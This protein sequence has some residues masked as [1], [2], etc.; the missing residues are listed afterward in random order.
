MSEEKLGYGV[1]DATVRLLRGCLKDIE[2]KKMG[3]KKQID[4]ARSSILNAE[5]H[6]QSLTEKE[7]A[8]KQTL[9]GIEDQ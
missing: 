6:L 7:V 2:S 5:Q 8:Y 4:T 9:Q 1:E 3:L